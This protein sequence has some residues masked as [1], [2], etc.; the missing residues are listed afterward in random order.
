[1]IFGIGL[2]LIQKTERA[3]LSTPPEPVAFSL[4]EFSRDR[5]VF[6]SG[7]ARGEQ[8]ASVPISGTAADG[9]VV[10]YRVIEEGG[11]ALSD[12]KISEPVTN[13]RWAGVLRC[14]LNWIWMR[15]EA[16]LADQPEEVLTT[17]TRFGVGHV[18]ALWSGSG[19]TQYWSS[20]PSTA[21]SEPLPEIMD[22]V[23]KLK[24][25]RR[26][27]GCQWTEPF[28]KPVLDPLPAGCSLNGLKL[29]INEDCAFEGWD[30]TGYILEV[31][32]V[33]SLRNCILG[34]RDGPTGL[35]TALDFYDTGGYE[36]IEYCDFIGPSHE[37]G[38]GLFLKMRGSANTMVD[39]PV[40]QRNRLWGFQSDGIKPNKGLIA[41][42]YFDPQVNL[43]MEP[44]PYN[45]TDTFPTGTLV[46]TSRLHVFRALEDVTGIAPPTSK[47]GPSDVWQNLDPHADSMTVDTCLGGCV[48]RGNYFNRDPATRAH[49]APGRGVTG[50]N[51]AVRLV[52]N[53]T[54]TGSGVQYDKVTVEYNY[55]TGEPGFYPYPLQA[56]TGTNPAP[57][58]DPEIR[59][60][61]IMPPLPGDLIHPDTGFATLIWTD[62]KTVD[63]SEPEIPTNSVPGSSVAID[64]EDTV[65]MMW[66][67]RERTG[68]AG[69]KHAF[70][71]ADST[72][73]PSCAALASGLMHKYPG[74]R[75]CI[76]QHTMADSSLSDLLTDSATAG[77][78]WYDE[79]ALHSA[80][81]SDGQSVGLACTD[82]PY[83][84]STA[85]SG[86]GELI[87]A[88]LSGKGRDGSDLIT[89]SVVM[90]SG[91]GDSKV[92]H[93]LAREL[94]ATDETRWL[95]FN[96]EV[97]GISQDMKNGRETF[98]GELDPVAISVEG[99]R[100][101]ARTLFQDPRLA[102][103]VIDETAEIMTYAAEQQSAIPKPGPDGA[104]RSARLSA[105]N[106]GRGL[107]YRAYG[108]PEFDRAYWEPTGA[109]VEL[110]WSGGP[111][112][113]TRRARQKPTLPASY[114]HW[115]E[116][117][118]FEI[119]GAPATKTEIANGRVRILPES[120][121]FVSS[122]TI[123]FGTGRG[124]GQLKYPEDYT[125]DTWQDLPIVDLEWANLE[126][127]AVRP[128]PDAMVVQN[129]I[130][131]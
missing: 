122:D 130:A 56:K 64:P 48:I 15:I 32:A 94:Y 87:A 129:T 14:P 31:R 40:F 43:N 110:W 7:A 19:A 118:G 52:R 54:P 6:D 112:T 73:P 78:G 101:G 41:F 47:T 98:A 46:V 38:Q 16:R 42:N 86:D 100:L 55:I 96:S 131:P 24:D 50:I 97:W 90:D 27:N 91:T 1:M 80:A 44:L 106:I 34:E 22:H 108:L 65:Q 9:S 95:L 36:V 107:S 115:T 21:A 76:I 111:V 59:H 25:N 62:N 17:Q 127:A 92:L 75:I 79:F 126:G 82:W 3:G 4:S 109:Y 124:T 128:L 5:T 116:V 121:Q 88:F 8:D 51:N 105:F 49:P 33:I 45:D 71:G 114:S 102:P 2:D 103:I 13:G 10:E 104:T 117:F 12:W 81:T 85:A 29:R 30:F 20:T 11:T 113:T 39:W 84:S 18:V 57:F 69:V 70:I 66:H 99:A 58:A 61:L 67:D 123:N 63:G 93:H 26:S 74:D 37:D 60:N 35:L 119:N 77:R 125:A 83:Q 53:N 89:P 120:G 23:I 72:L 28:K 68:P